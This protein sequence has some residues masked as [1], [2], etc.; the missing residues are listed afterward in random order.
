[1]IRSRKWLLAAAPLLLSPGPTLAQQTRFEPGI[2]G[3]L[4]SFLN[5]TT[6]GVL[7]DGTLRR[8]GGASFVA[9]GWASWPDGVAMGVDA[10]PMLRAPGSGPS[11]F[12]RGGMGFLFGSDV[13]GVGIHVG[14]GLD[15][16]P[17]QGSGVR[18]EAAYHRYMT[19]GG[20]P[21][22]RVSLSLLLPGIQRSRPTPSGG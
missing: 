8:T 20:V 6:A 1:M 17:V 7:V 21:L 19:E 12:L 13:S 14:M 15:V 18:L 11:L 3:G 16:P 2:G 5:G 22:L 4:F 10:G 9:T